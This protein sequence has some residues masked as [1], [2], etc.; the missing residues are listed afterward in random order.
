MAEYDN[1]NKGALFKNKKKETD[2]HPDYNGSITVDGT[3]YW[4]SSWLKTSKN[5]EKFMS[6]SVKPKQ[7]APRQSSAPTRREAP[8]GKSVQDMDSDIP[9]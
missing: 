5:G 4:I 6:L 1:N 8:R 7:D 2:N 3:E 9:W